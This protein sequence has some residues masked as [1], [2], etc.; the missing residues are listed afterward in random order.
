MSYHF[1]I[2]C[3]LI[4]CLINPNPLFLQPPSININWKNRFQQV[5]KIILLNCFM[6]T[7]VTKKLNLNYLLE[8][9]YKS[10]FIMLNWP[11]QI[12][13]SVAD[14]GF[15]F[16]VDSNR[17]KILYVSET[18]RRILSFSQVTNI[19]KRQFDFWNCS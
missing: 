9:S 12:L 11:H 13:G 1:Y 19:Y 5:K 18:V 16:V 3:K 17:G 15:L 6:E 10:S 7:Y 2:N 8:T 4:P 14:D